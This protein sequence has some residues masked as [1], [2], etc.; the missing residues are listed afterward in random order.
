MGKKI[1]SE[2][3]RRQQLMDRMFH[4]AKEVENEAPP[5]E[6]EEDPE[7]ADEEWDA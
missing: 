1:V 2:D 6:K 3:E 4:T 5:V 7:V